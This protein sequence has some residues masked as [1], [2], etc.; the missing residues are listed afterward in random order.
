MTAVAWRYAGFAQ[1]TVD[2]LYRIL[3]LRQRVFVVE[4]ACAYLDADGHDRAAHHLWTDSADGATARACLRVFAP[5]V[6]YAEACLGRVVTA[7]EARRTGLGRALVAEGLARIAA[8]H[9]PVPVRIGAQ[10]YLERFYRELGFVTASP[11]YDEDGIPHVEM[12]RPGAVV[13]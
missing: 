3:A 12:V 4:Q 2:E 5:G 6:K 9:G 11:E 13:G 1:L 10:R 8:A 7:P